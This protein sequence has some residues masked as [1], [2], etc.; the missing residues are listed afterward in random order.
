MNTTVIPYPPSAPTPQSPQY[1]TAPAVPAGAYA[2]NMQ[3]FVV[4]SATN[5]AVAA[6]A[7][8]LYNS[9]GGLATGAVQFHN[10]PGLHGYQAAAQPHYVA[11][12]A[13]THFATV[14]AAQQGKKHVFSF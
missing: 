5:Y 7:P 14:A 3:Y 4:P 13:Q 11:D 2:A 9:Q 1:P 12:I 8:Q 6:A 10:A